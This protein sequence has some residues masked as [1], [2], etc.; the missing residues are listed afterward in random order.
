MGVHR[1]PPLPGKK[2]TD[3]PRKQEI[4]S[5]DHRKGRL[6]E[7][8]ITLAK[9]LYVGV[10]QWGENLQSLLL[11]LHCIVLANGCPEMW[12][13]SFLLVLGQL[14]LLFFLGPHLFFSQLRGQASFSF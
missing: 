8:V 10:L 2:K 11:L 3:S 7:S 14:C 5:R 4:C 1:V 6:E 12:A 9:H 13:F